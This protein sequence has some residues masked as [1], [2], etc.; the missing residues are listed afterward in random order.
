[1]KATVI[2]R[3]R[4]KHT[5]VVYNQG[6][7]FEGTA[8]RIKELQE[9]KWVGEMF[10]EE[11]L[12]DPDEDRFVKKLEG[13]IDEIKLEVDGLMKS[14]FEKLIALEEKGKN[15][16]SLIEFFQTQAEMAGLAEPPDGE[17]E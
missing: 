12:P 16:K 13:S 7:T 6:K 17:G 15:R 4:D 9:K 3:F 14:D 8:D 10:G 5:K 1:M 11:E 2:K